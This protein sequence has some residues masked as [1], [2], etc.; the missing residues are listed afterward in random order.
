MITRPRKV[1]PLDHRP[2]HTGRVRRPAKRNA[3]TMKRAMRATCEMLEL[4]QMLSTYYVAPAP[5]G[6]DNNSGTSGSPFL[7][8]QKAISALGSSSGTINIG[9]GTYV[10]GDG[11]TNN[12]GGI[13]LP[14]QNNV[15]LQSY[16]G[17]VNIVGGMTVGSSWTSDGSGVYHTTLTGVLASQSSGTTQQTVQQVFDNFTP[18]TTSQTQLAQYGSSYGYEDTHRVQLPA[19]SPVTNLPAGGFYLNG[20]SNTLYVHLTGGAVPG[21]SGHAITVANPTVQELVSYTG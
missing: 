19:P 4:R 9:A 3:E 16:N 10:L 21:S 20:F 13:V 2:R 18:G 15:T 8:I 7:H 6:S 5:A 17:T 14:S 12:T 11:S 1:S